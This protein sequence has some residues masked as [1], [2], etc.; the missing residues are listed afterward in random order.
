MAAG[1]FST[2]ARPEDTAPAIE[3]LVR[4]T[5]A[6]RPWGGALV[7][8]VGMWTAPCET[9][10]GIE[11]TYLIGGEAFDWLALAERLLRAVPDTVA[12]PERER[13]LSTGALPPGVTPERF[14]EAL[15]V[16]KYRAHL[17]FF[18]GV[19]VEE[20]LWLAVEREMLKQ[21]GVR[22]R[23]D[24]AGVQDLVMRR[25]YGADMLPL[26]RRFNRERGHARTVRFTLTDWKA[27]TYWAF[28]L[29]VARS[30]SA[31]TA[32]DTRKGLSVLHELRGDGELPAPA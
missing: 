30:D 6:G 14:K 10:D 21:A 22:G 3:H 17:N 11:L 4:E 15:G 2:G 20:A 13:L 32:S 25:L 23:N 19:V 12:A 28:K 24:G 27:F 16:S 1:D 31:R 29:R 7:E 9:I 26:V 5:G 18:Y 8:A